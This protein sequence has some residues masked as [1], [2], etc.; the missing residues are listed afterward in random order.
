VTISRRSQ[1]SVFRF[2]LFGLDGFF[3]LHIVKF[4]GVKDFA[5]L[6]TLDKLGVVVP[7][8][9]THSWV[10]ADRCHRFLDRLD[11]GVSAICCI[12]NPPHT[13]G[14]IVIP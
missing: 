1:P 14:E 5:T 4:F 12:M 8:D 2:C 9:N 10:F 13:R 7:G 11:S 6:Q 3:D